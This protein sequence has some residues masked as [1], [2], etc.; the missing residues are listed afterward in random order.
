LVITAYVKY[1]VSLLPDELLQPKPG[2][3]ALTSSL[4]P[5]ILSAAKDLWTRRAILLGGTDPSLRSG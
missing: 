4:P 5:V 3:G 2:M 1:I